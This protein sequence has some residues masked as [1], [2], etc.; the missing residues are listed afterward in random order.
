MIKTFLSIA[1]CLFPPAVLS[2]EK[3]EPK[4]NYTLKIGDRSF[5]I[6]EGVPFDLKAGDKNQKATL[7]A[8]TYRT[9]THQ[10]LNFDY[11][12]H[13]SFEA[14]L[15]NLQ[16]KSWT[17]SG[18]D[19]TVMVFGMGARVTHNEMAKEMA[20]GFGKKNSK[21]RKT[22]LEL[23]KKEY[24]VSIID[25]TI[26]GTDLKLEIFAIELSP[27]S[28]TLFIIQDSL[29]DDGKHSNDYQVLRKFLDRSFSL[30]K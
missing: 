24:N 29:G 12:A 22:L 26:A 21:T 13:Y 15:T 10:N 2:D 17:L 14:D 25:V 7:T 1:I 9:F 23:G 4:R 8:S 11:P 16:A 30:K 19:C 28:S 27:N 3:T 6:S 18:N 20:N 5:Q